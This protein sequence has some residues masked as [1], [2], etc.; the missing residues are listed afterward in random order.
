M[1]IVSVDF[2]IVN[3]GSQCRWVRNEPCTTMEFMH[4]VLNRKFSEGGPFAVIGK[5]HGRIDIR[6]AI[7]G[8]R[9]WEMEL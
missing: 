3:D 5:S 8:E 7:P 9:Y 1:K 2:V 6:G 4:G